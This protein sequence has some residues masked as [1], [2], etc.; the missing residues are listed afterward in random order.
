MPTSPVLVWGTPSDVELEKDGGGEF[1]TTFKLTPRGL[2]KIGKSFGCDYFRDAEFCGCE[3]PREGD[4][5]HEAREPAE[6]ICL[7]SPMRKPS[8]TGR[9]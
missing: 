7:A 3:D 1:A 4:G 8:D 5:I 6:L 9:A 2:A